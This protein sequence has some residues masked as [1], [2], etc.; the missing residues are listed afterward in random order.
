MDLDSEDSLSLGV[1]DSNEINPVR[2]K[3]TVTTLLWQ[4]SNINGNQSDEKDYI[5]ELEAIICT[6]KMRENPQTGVVIH[7]ILA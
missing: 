5:D 6:P 4:Q 1:I 2:R 7:D 3:Q